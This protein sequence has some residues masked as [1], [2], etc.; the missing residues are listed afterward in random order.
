MDEEKKDFEVY[1]TNEEQENE[2]IKNL[3]C[4][5]HGWKKKKGYKI[6]MEQL[7]TD[8]DVIYLAEEDFS[9]YIEKDVEF[10]QSDDNEDMVFDD[11]DELIYYI[12][13]NSDEENIFNK[14]K[15]AK[16]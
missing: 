9:D 8:H 10:W 11:V 4:E 5:A 14:F 6:D 12:E 16:K 7:N 15:E 3:F 13:E 1:F 2:A